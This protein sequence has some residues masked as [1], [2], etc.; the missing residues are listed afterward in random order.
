[1]E[2]LERLGLIDE[3]RSP[4]EIISQ[5]VVPAPVAEEIPPPEEKFFPDTLED[6]TQV[7]QPVPVVPAPANSEQEL[8]VN[9]AVVV[10][11]PAIP[12][13]NNRRNRGN[14]NNAIPVP[15]PANAPQPARP[16]LTTRDVLTPKHTLPKYFVFLF[17]IFV[18]YKTLTEQ[19][20]ENCEV[21]GYSGPTFFN[22][23]A[24]ASTN[25]TTTAT[26]PTAA[27]TPASNE[28]AS[29][30]SWSWSWG[31]EVLTK[32]LVQI[33]TVFSDWSLAS[34]LETT[35]ETKSQCA[36]SR[37]W[38]YWLMA[39]DVILAIVLLSKAEKKPYGKYLSD[40]WLGFPF[41]T[42]STSRACV[43]LAILLETNSTGFSG[44][45]LFY[46]GLNLI[47]RPLCMTVAFWQV[48]HLFTTHKSSKTAYKGLQPT[49]Y[50]RVG[51]L[52]S[53]CQLFYNLLPA[54]LVALAWTHYFGFI[55]DTSYNVWTQTLVEKVAWTGFGFAVILNALGLI[56]GGFYLFTNQW[57]TCFSLYYTGLSQNYS[58]DV[59]LV[60]LIFFL[61]QKEFVFPRLG[62]IDS[63]YILLIII[64]LKTLNLLIHNE[65]RNGAI[66]RN[67]LVLS[68]HTLLELQSKIPAPQASSSKKES[69]PAAAR[70][71]RRNP[72]QSRKL[73]VPEWF[74][75]KTV[76]GDSFPCCICMSRRSNCVILPC[77]HSELCHVCAVD[78]MK[79]PSKRCYLCLQSI[80]A[81]HRLK[82]DYDVKRDILQEEPK[83]AAAAS[84]VLLPANTTPTIP[85]PKVP[86]NFDKGLLTAEFMSFE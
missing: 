44:D 39:A 64:A 84:D 14:H 67:Q 19:L 42:F 59:P 6:E 27:E 40:R 25:I 35:P 1:M 73:I 50:S 65:N 18:F 49:Y 80:N 29:S 3:K 82:I 8:V 43:A 86:R 77:Y 46:R 76:D 26:S 63:T 75:K 45:S 60:Y 37:F 74:N 7:A 55:S 5:P 23:T 9:P 21:I 31:V 38:Y 10:P 69:K 78:I 34:M 36:P 22:R 17:T 32:Q 85:D 70:K 62:E 54:T 83:P 41:V 81:I 47:W 4:E 56:V 79:N 58:I 12:V 52:K 24:T 71:Y 33:P 66:N 53:L 11:N 2:D 72:G 15:P 48:G 57:G 51:I 20:D 28:S 30:W 13:R 16:T 61:R 68:P